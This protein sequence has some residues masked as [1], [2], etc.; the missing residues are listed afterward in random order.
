MSLQ[1]GWTDTWY[2]LLQ[3]D[4]SK[5]DT[6]LTIFPGFFSTIVAAVSD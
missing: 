4:T 3:R 6:F 5:F 2:V 1:G